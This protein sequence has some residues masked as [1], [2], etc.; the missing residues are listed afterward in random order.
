[1]RKRDLRKRRA[2]AKAKGLVAV[3]K[4]KVALLFTDG[5][6]QLI[7]RAARSVWDEIAFDVLT[8]DGDGAG[9]GAAGEGDGVNG[10]TLP[11]AEVIELVSD[12][13]RL[14]DRLRVLTRGSDADLIN[15]VRSLGPMEIERVLTPAFPHERYGL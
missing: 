1:M 5:E 11:R 12:A 7:G 9:L 13:D 14:E 8:A 10:R 15:K 4:V 2:K 6:R 3:T